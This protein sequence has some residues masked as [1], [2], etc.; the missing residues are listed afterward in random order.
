MSSKAP[1]T[2]GFNP[3]E[4][5]VFEF[6]MNRERRAKALNCAFSLLWKHYEGDFKTGRSHNIKRW[7]KYNFLFNHLRHIIEVCNQYSVDQR[8]DGNLKFADLLNR[9]S[10]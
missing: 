2:L 4:Q 8:W 1:T 10:W 9:S 3:L 7:T 5:G 6:Y